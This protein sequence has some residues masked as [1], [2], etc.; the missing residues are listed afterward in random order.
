[1]LTPHRPAAVDSVTALAGLIDGYQTTAVLHAAVQLGLPDRLEGGPS[2][3]GVLANAMGADADRLRRLLGALAALGVC[4]EQG[5][6]VFALTEAG[7]ALTSAS[8]SGLRQRLL[9]AATH[10]AP[11]WTHIERGV[12]HGVT[13][14]DDLHGCT[15]WQYRQRHPAAGELFNTWLELETG[16]LAGLIAPALDL[17]GVAHVADIGGGTGALLNALLELH[18]GLEATLFDQPHVVAQAEAH[19]QAAGRGRTPATVGGDFMD[20]I[21]VRAEAYILKSILHDWKDPDALR[22][23]RNC[24]RA[25]PSGARLLLIERV[26]PEHPPDDPATH[27]V[28]L[29]M[30][31]VTGGRER[32]LAQFEA[33]LEGAGLRPGG[34]RA[35]PSAFTVIEAVAP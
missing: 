5:D 9:L 20:E 32:S 18:Q 31:L 27:M 19:W 22:I 2:D 35:T 21:P 16:R 14:F 1:M 7:H 23:L 3:A 10:Y 24:R 28:D 15:P 13:A 34:H 4:R 33:L 11:V 26:L 25:M 17:A 8:T 6:G 12:R 30:M 29:H